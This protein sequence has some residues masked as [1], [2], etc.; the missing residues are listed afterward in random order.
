M[1]RLIALFAVLSGL[2][3]TAANADPVNF[4]IVHQNITVNRSAGTAQFSI[5][6]SGTPDF[7]A[8]VGGQPDALQYEIDPNST[9]LKRPIGMADIAAVIRGGE[10]SASGGG[11]PIRFRTGDGGP[12]SG[13]WGPIRATLPFQLS[14]ATLKFTAPLADLGDT[15]GEFRFRAFTTH[16]GAI[17]AQVVGAVIPLPAALAPGLMLLG[18]LFAVRRSRLIRGLV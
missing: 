3:A 16:D 17:T 15:T 5:T 9:S 7:T 8:R 18:V 13:G 14:S 12:N 10:I 2:S 1:R 11:L 6:F 4:Q